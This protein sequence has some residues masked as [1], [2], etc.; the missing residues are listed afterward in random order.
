M[1]RMMDMA[2]IL[3]E[4]GK[5]N[6]FEALDTEP[7]ELLPAATETSEIKVPTKK[8]IDTNPKSEGY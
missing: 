7:Q 5:E 3:I 8:K 6:D 2:V 4:G 1:V